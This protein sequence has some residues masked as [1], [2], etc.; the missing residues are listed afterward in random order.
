MKKA[1]PTYC[2]VA[3]ISKPFWT[4]LKSN[5]KKLCYSTS[6]SS[7]WKLKL[8]VNLG[9]IILI[10]KFS[11]GQKKCVV[12]DAMFHLWYNIFLFTLFRKS[13]KMFTNKRLI[14]I[15]KMGLTRF[16]RLIRV[17][18][19]FNWRRI[20]NYCR[21]R[22]RI[23]WRYLGNLGW[24]NRHWRVNHT[25]KRPQ[26]IDTRPDDVTHLSKF[27]TGNRQKSVS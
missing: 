1:I 9:N 18:T 17:V 5:E 12:P 3:L 13:S 21:H 7:A 10:A 22:R 14:I 20:K 19:L 23:T 15:F 25:L 24:W 11:G 8:I 16:Y 26:E 2:H 27:E 4:I 6:F